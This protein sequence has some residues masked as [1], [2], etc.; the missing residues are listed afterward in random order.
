MRL[1][2]L[3]L[4]NKSFVKELGVLEKSI[5]FKLKKAIDGI[6]QVIISKKEINTGLISCIE[7]VSTKGSKSA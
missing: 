7:G 2:F 3:Y 5:V 4:I 6:E 1:L